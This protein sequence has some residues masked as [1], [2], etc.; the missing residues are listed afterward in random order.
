MNGR[1]IEHEQSQVQDVVAHP[2]I[3]QQ[4]NAGKDDDSCMNAKCFR[5]RTSF[6]TYLWSNSRAGVQE[7]LPHVP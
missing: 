7:N 3:Y 1:R 2:P 6:L 5:L 4:G